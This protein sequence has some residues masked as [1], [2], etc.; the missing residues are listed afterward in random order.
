MRELDQL[1]PIDVFEDHYTNVKFQNITTLVKSLKI[2]V[3]IV[4]QESAVSEKHLII[5]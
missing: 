2:A 4:I 5:Y 1:K 3:G